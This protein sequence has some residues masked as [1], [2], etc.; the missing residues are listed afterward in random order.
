MHSTAVQKELPLDPLVLKLISDFEKSAAPLKFTSKSITRSKVAQQLRERIK[1]P[2]AI[3][4]IGSPLCGP[5]AFLYVLATHNK[6]AYARYIIDLCNDGKATIG[7]LKVSPSHECLH[8]DPEKT[9]NATYGTPPVAACDWIGMASLRD[10]ENSIFSVTPRSSVAGITFPQTLASWFRDIGYNPVQNRTNTW[11]DKSLHNLA[12]ANRLAASSFHAVALFVN[13]KFMGA[14]WNMVPDHWVVL[15]S[16]ITIDKEPISAVL[17]ELRQVQKETGATAQEI[18][19]PRDAINVTQRSDLK[20]I[21]EIMSR[22]IHFT[23]YSWGDDRRPINKTRPQLT[24]GEF[25]DC[26]YG[27]VSAKPGVVNPSHIK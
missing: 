13:A 26:Y 11:F 16:R 3:N 14:S 21:D 4:Q 9:A 6:T 7:A 1:H 12:E 17:H 23:I 19:E 2:Y 25:L 8:T 20:K 27:F 15:T 5:A 10:S 24:L 18:E 22:K